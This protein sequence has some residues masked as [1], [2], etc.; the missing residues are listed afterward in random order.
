MTKDY[1]Q[2]SGRGR[3]NVSTASGIMRQT[4]FGV[5]N[6]VT[7]ASALT[8]AMFVNTAAMLTWG[9]GLYCSLHS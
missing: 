3:F 1:F 7:G 5:W 2:S 4:P 9:A 8:S 6:A